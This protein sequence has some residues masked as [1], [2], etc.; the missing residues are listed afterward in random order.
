MEECFSHSRAVERV[1]V[2]LVERKA[3]VLLDIRYFIHRRAKRKKT[4]GVKAEKA[5]HEKT[6]KSLPGS[7]SIT[8]FLKSQFKVLF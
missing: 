8:S 5:P 2:V 6:L 4:R 1:Q 3:F 7:S